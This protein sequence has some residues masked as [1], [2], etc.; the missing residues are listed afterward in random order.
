M[1]GVSAY[2]LDKELDTSSPSG[3]P[4]PIQDN[5]RVVDRAWIYR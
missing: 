3:E 2:R 5:T 1:I 4:R